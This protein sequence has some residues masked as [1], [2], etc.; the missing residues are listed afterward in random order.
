MIRRHADVFT[1]AEYLHVGPIDVAVSGELAQKVNLRLSGFG[2]NPRVATFLQSLP[3]DFDGV[4][5]GCLCHR[6]LIFENPDLHLSYRPGGSISLQEARNC[7]CPEKLNG[8]NSRLF[9]P[10]FVPI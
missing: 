2:D 9:G 5:G 6:L 8:T 10:G 4:V 7:S 3:Y 1:R